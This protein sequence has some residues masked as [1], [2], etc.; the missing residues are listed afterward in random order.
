MT[1][2]LGLGIGLQATPDTARTLYVTGE[3][4][5]IA[6]I[7]ADHERRKLED[8]LYQKSLK[9]FTLPGNYKWHRLISED[10]IAVSKDAVDRLLA[11]KQSGDPNWENEIV[12]IGQDY[13]ESM[14]RLVP[15]NESYHHFDQAT[16]Q[17]NKTG[18][19][20]TQNIQNAWRAFN[21]A[22]DSR[23]LV[24]KFQQ[25]GVQKD[26]YF[27]FNQ[28]GYVDVNA[29]QR[30]NLKQTMENASNDIKPVI[31]KTQRV[32]INGTYVDTLITEK[33]FTRAD[34]QAEYQ[35]APERFTNGVPLSIE[36]AAEVLLLDDDFRFQFSDINKLPY[37]DDEILKREIMER[38]RLG[39]DYKA[40]V[41]YKNKSKGLSINVGT[42]GG[43]DIGDFNLEQD[44]FDS[45][46]AIGKGQDVKVPYYGSYQPQIEL[47][48]QSIADSFYLADGSKGNV[49]IKKTFSDPKFDKFVIMPYYKDGNQYAP[50]TDGTTGKKIEGFTVFAV[51]N[52][53][54]LSFMQAYSKFSVPNQIGRDATTRSNI[55]AKTNDMAQ[56]VKVAEAAVSKFKPGT[57]NTNSTYIQEFYK[58]LNGSQ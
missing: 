53:D 47:T 49:G 29:P 57:P 23:D 7:R 6:R 21:E 54:K 20:T 52:D 35:R 36:D 46:I 58:A 5:K 22:K 1:D 48:S 31:S 41:A 26:R 33:P 25:F 2:N 11:A 32:L 40:K 10:A 9:D 50:Y 15:L 56:A 51:V 12:K 34:A 28:E 14:T 8:D 4:N 17:I 30:I 39:T 16:S 27:V 43:E 3:Q 13:N 19:Y 37:E 38:L 18:S 42:S 44:S 24:T 45:G 55:I